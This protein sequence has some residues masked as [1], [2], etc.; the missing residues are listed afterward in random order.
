M[1]IN[2]NM[3]L[4]RRAWEQLLLKPWMLT[5]SNAEG[6]SYVS[7]YKLLLGKQRATMLLNITL[8]ER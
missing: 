2:I 4:D 7:V 3:V 8:G 1:F 6:I 5:S